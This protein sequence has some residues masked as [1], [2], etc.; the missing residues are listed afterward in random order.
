MMSFHAIALAVTLIAGV[1]NQALAPSRQELERVWQVGYERA[2][3]ESDLKSAL[4]L[5]QQ[6]IGT[7]DTGFHRRTVSWLTFEHPRLT[8]FR[9]GFTARKARRSEADPQ[10]PDGQLTDLANG[11][12]RR[13][14]FHADIGVYPTVLGQRVVR[15][16]HPEDLKD[17]RVVLRVGDR[18]YE[19]V[20]QPGDVAVQAKRGHFHSTPFPPYTGRRPHENITLPTQVGYTWYQA[21]FDF[22]FDL[23]DP[24]GTPRI[25]D[26]DTEFT[27]TITSRRGNRHATYRLSEWLTAYER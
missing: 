3:K 24:D 1:L 21:Q 6:G 23:Y 25:T 18:T 10:I 16:A 7:F 9:A 4:R 17:T 2:G 12:L 15:G 11:R 13:L 27:I 26:R 19:P 22:A 5:A 8:A 14:T 20:S